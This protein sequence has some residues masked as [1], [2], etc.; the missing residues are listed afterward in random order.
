MAQR[1]CCCF[2]G[3]PLLTGDDIARWVDDSREDILERVDGEVHDDLRT[4][5]RWGFGT[6]VDPET[7]ED[8]P[9]VCPFLKADPAPCR[10]LIEETRPE[11][12]RG[13]TP[14]TME[15]AL[16]RRVCGPDE[17]SPGRHPKAA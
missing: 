5:E 16:N 14:E 2:T 12:C 15:S 1:G 6:F 7:G 8:M 17:E 10:C 11:E 9:E 4:G 13:T 3:G